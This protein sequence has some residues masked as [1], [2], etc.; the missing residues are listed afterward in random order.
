[1][2]LGWKDMEWNDSGVKRY[3]M[4]WFWGEKIWNEMIR[5][6]NDPSF[7]SFKNQTFISFK[8]AKKLE[9]LTNIGCKNR[10]QNWAKKLCKPCVYWLISQFSW[11]ILTMI[12]NKLQFFLVLVIHQNF[13]LYPFFQILEF[14]EFAKS[15]IIILASYFNIHWFPNFNNKTV[16]FGKPLRRQMIWATQKN[17]VHLLTK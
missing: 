17:Q 8:T 7:H 16:D 12:R 3:G 9:K 14:S 1:M 15:K 6:W 4:K 5:R 2:I 13:N 10:I 11:E